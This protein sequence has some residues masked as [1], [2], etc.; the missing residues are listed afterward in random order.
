M[1]EVV[2]G[3]DMAA[4]NSDNYQSTAG[5]LAEIN[6]NYPNDTV[7]QTL[8]EGVARSF[9]A[10]E[11]VNDCA[12]M[13]N[14]LISMSLQGKRVAIIGKNSYYW[15]VTYLAVT[16]S[17]ACAA[18]LDPT[19]DVPA[20]AQQLAIL[21]CDL[22]V[23]D[24][25]IYCK[26]GSSAPKCTVVMLD[27]YT[28]YAIHN[29]V[30]SFITMGNEMMQKGYN[31]FSHTKCV[32]G[33]ISHMV[34]DSGAYGT[35]K[36]VMLSGRNVY[37]QVL[38][39]SD[40]I[41]KCEK[42]LVSESFFNTRTL[43]CALSTI[44]MG[45]CLCICE[46]PIPEYQAAYIFSADTLTATP[47]VLR[48]LYTD[49]WHEA[50]SC[51][52]LSKL[53][54]SI[55]FNIFLNKLGIAPRFLTRRKLVKSDICVLRRI[56]CFGNNIDDEVAYG[57]HMMGLCVRCVYEAP[58]CGIITVTK[59]SD[60]K[61][62]TL[63]SPIK[64]VFIRIDDAGRIHVRSDACLSGYLGENIRPGDF[65]KTG[66]TGYITNGNRLVLANNPGQVC[67]TEYGKR[68]FI[69]RLHEK[70]EKQ[71]PYARSFSVE[72]N[73][74]SVILTVAFDADFLGITGI[75]GAQTILKTSV[76]NVNRTLCEYERITDIIIDD[77][78]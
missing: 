35:D 75:S 17:G 10:A 25:D 62:Q 48:E 78:K 16:C 56:L 43:I 27:N 20:I 1:Q 34:F 53:T 61:N 41:N 5:L 28:N 44:F 54:S 29:T 59:R 22:V 38:N 13:G 73:G 71:L 7:V 58:E 3:A 24:S 70:L 45:A 18:V 63:G 9:T 15:L 4:G 19:L 2:Y 49:I 51:G 46:N 69:D 12:A 68:I 6:I 33:A 39:A 26:M 72:V 23:C 52:I 31:E 65:I 67:I 66:D 11:L 40:A 60:G 32:P 8:C 76:D 36:A 30:C 55:K 74:K 64:G 42:V 50:S 37:E 21:N 47:K 57:L 14:V 77:A